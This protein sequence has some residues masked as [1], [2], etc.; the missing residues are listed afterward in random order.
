MTLSWI[1][2]AL[3]ALFS[4][5]GMILLFKKITMEGVPPLVLLLFLFLIAGTLY[6]AQTLFTRTKVSLSVPVFLLIL[7]AAILSYA[8]NLFYLKAIGL[9]PNPGYAVA[10]VGLQAGVIAFGAFFLFNSE[11]SLIKGVGLLLAILAT[12]LLSV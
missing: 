10:V 12:I 8:G 3:F 7:A 9:A 1:F 6:L 2:Y 5:A 4:F 11:L